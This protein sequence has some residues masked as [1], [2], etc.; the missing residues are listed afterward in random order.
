MGGER[1]VYTNCVLVQLTW[2]DVF[3]SVFLPIH[4]LLAAVCWIDVLLSILSR[5]S[6]QTLQE[7]R[8]GRGGE[9]RERN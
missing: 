2:N 5:L 8:G 4:R 9:G 1:V 6:F 7:G 3:E